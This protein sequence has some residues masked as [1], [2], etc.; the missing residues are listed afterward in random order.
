M[1]QTRY[2]KDP[3]STLDYLWDWAAWLG[4]DTI[5]AAQIVVSPAGLTAGVPTVE[6]DTAVRCWLSGGTLGT[7]Y[8]VTCRITTAGGR[9][10]DWTA[11]I[12]CA[13]R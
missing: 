12:L 8:D 2:T 1:A 5:A 7:R 3:D 9:I 13:Q 4:E 10:D 11:E 6:D